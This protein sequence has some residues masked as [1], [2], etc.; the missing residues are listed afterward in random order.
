[1]SND[2][3]DMIRGLRLN[4]HVEFMFLGDHIKSILLPLWSNLTALP[5]VHHCKCPVT[6]SVSQPQLDIVIWD[7]PDSADATCRMF[8]LDGTPNT[9]FDYCLIVYD[10]IT[11]RKAQSL[12]KW[13]S[14]RDQICARQHSDRVC[15]TVV[16]VVKTPRTPPG[17]YEHV[18][19]YCN[20]QSIHLIMVDNTTDGMNGIR[21]LPQR[22]AQLTY[23]KRKS[24]LR[25][26]VD[27][28]LNESSS[29]K[30]G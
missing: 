13:T 19:E 9:G 14:V 1:M 22:L 27:S 3:A 25:S 15:S 20:T 28:I 7:L 8:P 6:A 5:G 21:D 24:Q 18:K 10:T 17:L 23:S 4:T 29:V 2:K 12:D 16:L 11:R 30:N 26:K